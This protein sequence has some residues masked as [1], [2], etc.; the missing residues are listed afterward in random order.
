VSDEE[1]EET[2]VGYTGT[3]GS[4]LKHKDNLYMAGYYV[5][6]LIKFI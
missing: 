1:F 4:L 5:G 2:A 6:K 3:K